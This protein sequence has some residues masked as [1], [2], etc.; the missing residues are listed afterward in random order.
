VKGE[1]FRT[2]PIGPELHRGG[3]LGMAG[4]LTLLADGTRT[5]PVRRAAWVR[6]QLLDDPPLP[7]PPNAGAIQPNAAGK[8]LTIRERLEKHRNEPT[9]ASC[10]RKLDSYGLALENYDAIG[11][12][13]TKQNGEG[14]RGGSLPPINPS[15]QLKSGLE[16]HDL[17]G[18]K[19]AL[20][21]EKD[22]FARA[23]ATKLLTYALC[24]PVG[25]V[26]H[27]TV[28]QVTQ[29]L[30]ADDYRLQ[31]LVNAVVASAPFQSR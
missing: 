29:T 12:W 20:L 1:A 31:T 25:Y 3:V 9:C 2:V 7:P 10:H 30:R 8:N 13:R 27:E 23:L 18:Y 24:R 17:A 6:G 5:L 4:L 14:L 11:A 19:A 28:D 26:D 16:F 15:G 21:T 22:K